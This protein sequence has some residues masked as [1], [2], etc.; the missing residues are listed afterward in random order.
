MTYLYL[1]T[2]FHRSRQTGFSQEGGRSPTCCHSLFNVCTRCHMLQDLQI[3]ATWKTL[4]PLNTT[5]SIAVH[6]A[7][8]RAREQGPS[9]WPY[10]RHRMNERPW[11]VAMK[12]LKACR[13]EVPSINE[14]LGT[15]KLEWSNYPVVISNAR[16]WSIA[17]RPPACALG[18]RDPSGKL[19][20]WT[21]WIK[22]S[23]RT[24]VTVWMKDLNKH[25]RYHRLYLRYE[26]PYKHYR[27][28]YRID[29]TARARARQPGPLRPAS[30]LSGAGH[31]PRDPPRDPSGTPLG[32]PP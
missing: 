30:A 4:G 25:K 28:N 1:R 7:R 16:P 22:T 9:G 13:N 6:P 3:F 12:T 31:P 21:K 19:W 32:T 20:Q 17:V 23:Y 24:D 10:N 18:S 11:K 2:T 14:Y 29:I 15:L 8:A 26:L 27:V 5:I